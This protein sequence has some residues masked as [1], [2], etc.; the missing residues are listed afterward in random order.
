MDREQQDFQQ[1]MKQ[2]RE[3]A[4]AYVSGDPEPLDRIVARSSPATFFGPNRGY[5]QGAEEVSATYEQGAA[6]F[7]P[8]S[9]TTLEVLQS[10]ASD[11]IAYWIGVQRA[12]VRMR[13]SENEI[14]MDLR[15]TEIFRREGEEWKLVHRHAD[16][17]AERKQ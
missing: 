8:G 4:R 14:P 13:G 9:E 17:L 12:K 7:Q 11:T 2:R 16:M 1:F 6:M 3:A 15:V 5:W 10:G